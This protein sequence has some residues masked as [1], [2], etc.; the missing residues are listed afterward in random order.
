VSAFGCSCKKWWFV[1]M[2]PFPKMKPVDL[3]SD[4]DRPSDQNLFI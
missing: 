1:S 2:L 4:L 3:L